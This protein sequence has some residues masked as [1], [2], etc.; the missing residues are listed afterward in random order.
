MPLDSADAQRLAFLRKLD[1]AVDR[2]SVTDWEAEFIESH[3]SKGVP[4]FSPKQRAV[5]DKM[6]ERYGK[7]IGW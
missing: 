1:E 5:I 4:D 6:V 3:L 7:Q 2:V